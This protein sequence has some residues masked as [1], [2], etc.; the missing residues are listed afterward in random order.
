MAFSQDGNCYSTCYPPQRNS[1]TLR[2]GFHQ[3]NADPEGLIYHVFICCIPDETKRAGEATAGSTG[4][5][6]YVV[7]L[8][9][10]HDHTYTTLTST[11]LVYFNHM[12]RPKSSRSCLVILWISFHYRWNFSLLLPVHNF[13]LVKAFANSSMHIPITEFSIFNLLPP[14]N[15]MPHKLPLTYAAY[16]SSLIQ[17]VQGDLS[18]SREYR[19]SASDTP[20]QHINSH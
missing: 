1:R 12:W 5:C 4:G 11:S 15:P 2:L 8:K 17:L 18:N 10:S 6:L 7:Y 14:Q 9:L 16:L 13:L 20:S 19:I 3:R